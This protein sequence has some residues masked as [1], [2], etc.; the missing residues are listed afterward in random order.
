[1]SGDSSF[2]G[3]SF[4]ELIAQ[5][6]VD[7]AN[8]LAEDPEWTTK[9]V[10]HIKSIIEAFALGCM[11]SYSYYN[12]FQIPP[13]YELVINK[14][15]LLLQNELYITEE[16]VEISLLKLRGVYNRLACSIPEYVAWN[17]IG[18]SENRLLSNDNES[19]D[20]PSFIDLFCPPHNAVIFLRD[21]ER[22]YQRL[23]AEF[24]DKYGKSTYDGE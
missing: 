7:A 21:K 12:N 18:T 9:I 14:M 11:Q 23:N 2:D 8:R 24:E 16:C 20:T 19:Q 3:L 17:E 1:M 5:A 6:H 22:D 13:N 15:S 10:I 4:G